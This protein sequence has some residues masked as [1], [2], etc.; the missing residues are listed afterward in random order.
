MDGDSHWIILD[1]TVIVYNIPK[2]FVGR[3]RVDKDF[4]RLVIHLNGLRL[5]DLKE[6]GIVVGSQAVIF[7]TH[8]GINGKNAAAAAFIIH[9]CNVIKLQCDHHVMGD[10]TGH[11]QVF[12]PCKL[13]G[14]DNGNTALLHRFIWLIRA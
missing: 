10:T 2:F 8:H 11:G 4:Y 6:K 12:R 7:G 9:G 3:E 14:T 13:Q 1:G 5:Q